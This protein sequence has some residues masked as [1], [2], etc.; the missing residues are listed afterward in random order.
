DIANA[1]VWL[2]SP[3]ASRH[4]SGEIVTVAGGMEGRVLWE[5]ESVD[6]SAVKERLR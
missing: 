6:V 2:L 4:V 3:A 1:L 5:A